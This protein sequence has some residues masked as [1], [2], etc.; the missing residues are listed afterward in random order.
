MPYTLP[1]VQP[2][3]HCAP[4]QPVSTPT[5][6]PHPLLVCQIGN[7]PSLNL[8]NPCS[9]CQD[10]GPFAPLASALLVGPPTHPLHPVELGCKRVP[11]V[12]VFSLPP[13]PSAPLSNPNPLL[14]TPTLP[15]PP[16]THAPCLLTGVPL[17]SAPLLKSN[18]YTPP[19][20]CS[21]WWP[22]SGA[23]PS[24]RCASSRPPAAAGR[25]LQLPKA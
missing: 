12:T 11:L 6:A 9:P 10:P 1:L 3:F 21:A 16:T 4:T 22:G 15:S 14:P 13:L 2:Q 25:Q 23:V 18:S 7:N 8:I 5:R 17:P 20:P 24:L 19:P